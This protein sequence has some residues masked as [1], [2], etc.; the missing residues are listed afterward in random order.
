MSKASLYFEVEHLN[1]KHGAAEIKRLLNTLPGV[2]SVS[3]NRENGRVAVDYDTTGTTRG[4]I[5]RQLDEMG[6][7]VSEEQLE[8]HVM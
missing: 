7:S 8:N 4:R 3:V 5:R 6:L 2:L 1:G